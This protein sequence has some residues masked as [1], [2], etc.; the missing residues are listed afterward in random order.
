MLA[1]WFNPATV[2]DMSKVATGNTQSYSRR[3]DVQ[4]TGHKPMRFTVPAGLF[5]DAAK[6]VRAH[7][8]NIMMA[9]RVLPRCFP[10]AT[11]CKVGGAKVCGSKA[12][13]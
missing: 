3:A 6:A 9:R 11:A 8:G 10:A 5:D 2:S 4:L 13:R 7:L 12:R 1:A